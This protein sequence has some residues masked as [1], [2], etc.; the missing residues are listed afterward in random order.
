MT[1]FV[2]FMF[3]AVMFLQ[4]EGKKGTNVYQ[5]MVEYSYIA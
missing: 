4:N 5:W 2:G 1:V 3:S